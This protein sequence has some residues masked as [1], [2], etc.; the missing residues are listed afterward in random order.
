[1]SFVKKQLNACIWPCAD[2]G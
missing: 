2:F 1:M